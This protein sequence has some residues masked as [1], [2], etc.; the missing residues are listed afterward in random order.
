MQKQSRMCKMRWEDAEA[1]LGWTKAQHAKKLHHLEGELDQLRRDKA[2]LEGELR[3]WRSKF[4]Q[5]D[6][7]YAA[8]KENAKILHDH[9]REYDDENEHRKAQTIPTKA[10]VLQVYQQQA[11]SLAA[12]AVH[13][14][15]VTDELLV[16]RRERRKT[17]WVT[18][19]KHQ[20]KVQSMQD[21]IESER[22]RN[23]ELLQ[24]LNDKDV[25]GPQP[26]EAVTTQLIRL[27]N[28]TSELPT[29]QQRTDENIQDEFRSCGHRAAGVVGL[30]ACNVLL[31]QPCH[32]ETLKCRMLVNWHVRECD[33]P[34]RAGDRQ[35][36][37]SC[38]RG[39]ESA[40]LGLVCGEVEAYAC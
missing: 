33:P 27:Y 37:R 15:K 18:L 22:Q 8:L 20:S 40:D 13:S 35:N 31:C 26:P 30:T 17:S 2:S 34:W 29:L 21:A 38:S 9:P 3:V 1:N 28:I 6:A 11:P 7:E 5:L 23:T 19:K 16:T 10:A 25:A 36:S 4:P 39:P 24:A 14:V 12:A 32:K